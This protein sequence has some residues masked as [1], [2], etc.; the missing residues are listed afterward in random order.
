[1]QRHCSQLILA[2]KHISLSH[3]PTRNGGAL[4]LKSLNIVSLLNC[5][6]HPNSVLTSICVIYQFW[7][8][9]KTVLFKF[10][11]LRKKAKRCNTTRFCVKP[12]CLWTLDGARE[13]QAY[14]G[15]I[16]RTFDVT[17]LWSGMPQCS[18]WVNWWFVL[19]GYLVC[20]TGNKR[21]R[22]LTF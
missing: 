13:G 4:N 21:K 10:I 3:I 20:L 18:G 8:L 14:I 5:I 16:W 15:A 6:I 7:I 17:L 1:M 2:E 11:I 9:C 22:S 19:V 12:K